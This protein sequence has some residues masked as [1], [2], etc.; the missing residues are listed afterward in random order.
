MTKKFLTTI[1]ILTIGFSAFSKDWKVKVM[2]INDTKDDI[3]VY[4]K[5]SDQVNS[6]QTVLLRIKL[7]NE[8]QID[9]TILVKQYS[10]ISAYATLNKGGKTDVSTMLVND[11]NMT[12]SPELTL[13]KDL[14]NDNK[15]S[16]TDFTTSPKLLEFDPKTFM[17]KTNSPKP[18]SELFN[19]FLGG[20]AICVNKNG[21]DSIIDRIE[22]RELGTE[23]KP[24]YN[25]VEDKKELYFTNQTD[26]NI[27]ASIPGIVQLNVNFNYSKL[28]HLK[29]V[30]KGVGEIGWQN[31]NNVDINKNFV[32]NVGLKTHYKLAKYK[33]SMEMI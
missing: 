1:L 9:T 7:K 17:N 14:T 15:P 23:M 22:P 11:K 19:Q 28:Y 10:I 27:K 18:I 26:Q 8:A 3:T 25:S 24:Y 13:P 4:V 5:Q 33:K 32:D 16:L 30:Y 2:L 20:L 12:F 21:K 29:I 6:S 31:V